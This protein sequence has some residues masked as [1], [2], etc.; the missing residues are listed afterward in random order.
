MKTLGKLFENNRAWAEGLEWAA[1]GFFRKL[2]EQQAPQYLWVGC[3]DSRVPATQLVGLTPG[4]VRGG[5]GG[6][7]PPTPPAPPPPRGAAPGGRVEGDRGAGF[8][9]G[10]ARGL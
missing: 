2:S 4:H 10:G 9:E 5:G 3:S 8:G 1:P 7:A 6:P